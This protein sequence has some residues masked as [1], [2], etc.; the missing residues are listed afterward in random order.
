MSWI[1]DHW[2]E[3]VL[4]AMLLVD[5]LPRLLGPLY[6]ELR[7]RVWDRWT[8]WRTQRRRAGITARDGFLP[9]QDLRGGFQYQQAVCT[10]DKEFL[11]S[12]IGG[13]YVHAP[14]CPRL[15]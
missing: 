2:A 3:L 7:F 11:D 12:A 15:Q 6:R 1:A 14:G 10:C 4:T 8:Y 9:P 5:V 13:V